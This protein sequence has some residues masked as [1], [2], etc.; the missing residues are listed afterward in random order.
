[1]NRRWPLYIL[2][3]VLAACATPPAILSGGVFS[4]VTVQDAQARDLTGQ[5]VRWGGTIVST[6]PE[7]NETC[8]EVVSHPL[9]RQ[10]RPRLTDES[11]GRFLACAAGFF[12]PAVYA[13]GREITVVGSLQ[14]PTTGK[15]GDYE[16][17]FPRVSAEHVYL[18]AKREEA[19]PYYYYDPW[20]AP[21]WYY[22]VWRPRPYW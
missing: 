13:P 19:Q 18:W 5:R 8:F 9:D 1:M 11:D 7:T 10:A 15:I 6:K 12:D 14:A 3:C 22:P 21:Y 17:R 16:Y 20:F 2:P 4:E